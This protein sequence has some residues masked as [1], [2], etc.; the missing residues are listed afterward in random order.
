[1]KYLTSIATCFVCF[2]VAAIAQAEDV[3]WNAAGGTTDV[4]N[5]T[6]SNTA[7]DDT[8]QSGHAMNWE[9]VTTN[10]AATNSGSNLWDM[11]FVSGGTN[12]TI[13]HMFIY[14]Q[15]FDL[16]T[17]TGGIEALTMTADFAT[18]STSEDNWSPVVA[19]TD[20]GATTYYRWNHSGNTYAGTGPLDFSQ[21]GTFDLSQL[22]NATNTTTV[23]WGELNDTA[24]G[25]G[26]TRDNGTN[27][28]LQAT[29]GTFQVGF[30]QW[31][32]ST[33]GSVNETFTTAIDSW[34]T[35]IT[36]TAVPEPSSMMLIGAGLGL[37]GLRR[38]R[39]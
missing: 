39:R 31:N 13:G 25:F 14:N 20:G 28:N 24:T 37:I 22:G 7:F 6:T 32:A 29:S 2:C 34:D 10:T 19:V 17:S 35:T 4:D 38:R 21:G 26:G 16:S 27:P 9:N 36:F 18:S 23:I 8:V 30:L 3:T 11:E 15:S 33:G 5:W 12:F 1:M